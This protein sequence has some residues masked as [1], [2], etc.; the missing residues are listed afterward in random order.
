M[1][2]TER[3][4]L[5][6]LA[7]SAMGLGAEREPARLL[8]EADR[9]KGHSSKYAEAVAL[10]Q[11]A[12]ALP[13]LT[14][15]ETLK[16]YDILYYVHRQKKRRAEAIAAMDG[17][18]EA[19]PDDAEAGRTASSRLFQE[20]WEWNKFDDGLARTDAFIQRRTADK[21]A[22]ADAWF[23]KSRFHQRKKQY[24]DSLAAGKA[25]I[26]LE[27]GND[28]RIADVL[29]HMSDV[30]WGANKME[31]AEAALRRLFEPK[32]FQ[33]RP[34]WDQLN[35][36]RRYGDTLDRL[37]RY[38]DACTHYLALEKQEKKADVAQDW[39][40]RIGRALMAQEK[41]DEALRAFERVFTA[42]GA[43]TTQWLSAQVTLVDI[44]QRQGK[45]K[46]AL[47][48]ARIALDAS[49]DRTQ[50]TNQVRTI[51]DLLR[52]IDNHVGRAN[53]AINYQRFGPDGEDKKPG[54][55]DDVKDPLPAL[56][57]PSYPE[58]ERAFEKTRKEAGDDSTASR[59]RAY[60]YIYTGKPKKALPHFLDALGRAQ[61]DRFRYVGPELII[62]GVRAARGYAGNLQ[63]FVDFVNYGPAGPDG[64]T[65]TA[66]D[67][68]DPFIAISK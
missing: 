46:E 58:R 31:E 23:W 28:K 54:T 60:T 18:L 12:L 65:G 15:D 39:C 13:A 22:C 35:A 43:V 50:I 38:A 17:L 14:R 30:A 33:H 48:A 68:K 67:L 64:K 26:G 16:A 51:A 61:S 24:D 4:L 45:L 20:Y 9:A 5:V 63:P 8:R 56:G 19:L 59:L 27:P 36:Q 57:Y 66:D 21:G 49:P 32:Y 11:K 42:H 53:L 37:K 7:L 55:A 52:R 1:G 2:K 6:L 10:C 25:A 34:E 3:T 44:L 29:W 40:L 47:Q 62:V 41:Y